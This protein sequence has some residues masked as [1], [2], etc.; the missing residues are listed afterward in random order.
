MMDEVFLESF[1]YAMILAVP[2]TLLTVA[3]LADELILLVRRS[4]IPY[5]RKRR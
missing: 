5:V 3:A 1:E 2:I 4:V